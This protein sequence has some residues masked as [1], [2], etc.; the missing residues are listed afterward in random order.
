MNWIQGKL[1]LEQYKYSYAWKTLLYNGIRTAG[2]SD[3]PVENSSP[4]KG[5][6]DAIYRW[7]F[8]KLSL[9]QQ[10]DENLLKIYRNNENLTFS[11]ALW[12]YT[13]ESSYC[14]GK[15]NYHGNIKE[16]YLGDFVLI[17][18]DIEDDYKKLYDT[19]PLLVIV[20][21]N[22]IINNLVPSSSTSSLTTVEDSPSSSSTSVN[23]D[24]NIYIPGK[25]GCY[26]PN[27]TQ[28]FH[29]M[30]CKCAFSKYLTANEKKLEEEDDQIFCQF[31]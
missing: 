16:N 15:N 28:G 12:L 29:F 19:L 13:I 21:G 2:G 10:K 6:Y 11:E 14:L 17:S 9:E 23:L 26:L 5:I 30:K 4:F 1:S 7:N 18:S 31:I 22:I 3:A 25:N 27:Q 24:G 20:N 8:N